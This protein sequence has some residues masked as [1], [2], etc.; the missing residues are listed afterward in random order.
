MK[1]I[2]PTIQWALRFFP[3]VKRSG[4]GIDQSP[5]SSAE[6][7]NEWSCA[8]TPPICL[9]GVERNQKALVNFCRAK[10]LGASP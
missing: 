7:K 10:G 2:Q 8:S 4:I 5:P 9:Y 1:P 6:V 3:G